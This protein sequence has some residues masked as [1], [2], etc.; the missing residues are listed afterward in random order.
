MQQ[1]YLDQAAQSYFS[2]LGA[3]QSGIGESLNT[4]EQGVEDIARGV[5]ESRAMREAEHQVGTVTVAPI[6]MATPTQTV[7]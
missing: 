3:L 1:P 4:A 2:G 5:G 6:R 7:I